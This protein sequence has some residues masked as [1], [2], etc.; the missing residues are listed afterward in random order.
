[1][2]LDEIKKYLKVDGNE[3]DD[4]LLGLQ[5]AAEEYLINA[6]AVKD[7]TKNLFKIAIK[8]LISHWYENRSAVVVGSISKN[9]EFSLSNIIIQLKYSG[10]DTI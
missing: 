8:L 6:G 9:M 4:L 2:E 5:G 1:M 10:G 3:E 7:Y